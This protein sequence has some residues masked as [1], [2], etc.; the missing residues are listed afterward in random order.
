MCDARSPLMSEL[1]N[2]CETQKGPFKTESCKRC[3]FNTTQ[4][5]LETKTVRKFCL[6]CRDFTEKSDTLIQTEIFFCINCRVI[7]SVRTALG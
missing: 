7:L 2:R 6:N 4:L 3:K 1:C 5:F